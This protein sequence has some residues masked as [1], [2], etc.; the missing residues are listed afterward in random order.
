MLMMTAN[1]DVDVDV[2]VKKEDVATMKN[3]QSRR[4]R[5]NVTVEDVDDGAFKS[6]DEDKTTIDG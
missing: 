1:V 3:R 4:R 6:N 5:N 2:D